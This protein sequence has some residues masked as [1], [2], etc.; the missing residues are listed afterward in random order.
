MTGIK[1]ESAYLLV[2]DWLVMLLHHLVVMATADTAS[3]PVLSV[4]MNY[5][6]DY[7]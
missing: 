6:S 1:R 2:A 3:A 4:T 5:M 7:N